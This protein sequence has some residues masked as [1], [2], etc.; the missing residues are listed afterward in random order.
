MG[1]RPSG[2]YTN[3]LWNYKYCSFVTWCKQKCVYLLTCL[4]MHTPWHVSAENQINNNK[5][6]FV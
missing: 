2:I 5:N 4:T 6:K 3:K 1:L